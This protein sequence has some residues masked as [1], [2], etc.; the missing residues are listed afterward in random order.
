[1][2]WLVDEIHPQAEVVRVV[3]NNLNTI[4]APRFMR[5]SLRK[6]PTN[7]AGNWNFISPPNMAAG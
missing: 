5:L 2:K 7:F 6:R 3:L 1:M 4:P